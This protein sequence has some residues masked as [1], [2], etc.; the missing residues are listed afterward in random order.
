MEGKNTYLRS[1]L[2]QDLCNAGFANQSQGCRNERLHAHQL[3]LPGPTVGRKEPEIPHTACDISRMVC[4]G[5]LADAINW[6]AAATI[7]EARGVTSGLDN[8]AHP[9]SSARNGLSSAGNSKL[10]AVYF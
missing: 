5:D 9:G 1:G 3:R 8:R 2:A 4:T 6:S 7:T 10:A